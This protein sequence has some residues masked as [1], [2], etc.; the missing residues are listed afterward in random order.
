MIRHSKHL[1]RHKGF[2]MRKYLFF[3]LF[4][5]FIWTTSHS[6]FTKESESFLYAKIDSLKKAVSSLNGK[7]KVD[8]LNSIVDQYQI[9]DEDNQMQID[10]AGPYAR[11][12]HNYAVE[13]GYKRGLGYACLKLGYINLVWATVHKNDK[14]NSF[15]YAD[16]LK[17][18]EK[19]ITEAMQ[20]SKEINDLIMRG[21]AYA[22]LA[23]LEGL[24]GN[25]AQQL[26]YHKEA[27]SNIER[28]T[29]QPKG[30][31][32]EQVYINCSECI[33]QEFRLAELYGGLAR[34]NSNKIEAKVALRKAVELYKK[35][36]AYPA[37]SNTYS[38]LISLT[39][40]NANPEGGTEII[41][42]AI[43]YFKKVGD[44]RQ[45]G[46]FYRR[47]ATIVGVK[48]DSEVGIEYFKKALFYSQEAGDQQGE[49]SATTMISASSFATGD[50]ENSLE[51][52][53]KSIELVEKMVAAQGNKKIK[54]DEWG[55]AYYWMARIYS[56]AGGDYETALSFMRKSLLYYNHSPNP[57][58]LWTAAIGEIY[59]LKGD[60]DSS[61]YYLR[62][63]EKSPGNSVGTLYLGR[64]YISLGQYDKALPLINN[65]LNA[66]N[67]NA[68]YGNLGGGYTDLAKVWL[69]K[70][71]YPKALINARTGHILLKRTKRNDRFI[72]NCQVLSEIFTKVR[73]YDS[74]YFYLKQYTYLKD[75]FLTRQF[76]IRLN[77]YKKQAE[78]E[79]KTS[80]INLLNKDNQLKEQKLKQEA[81][82]KKGLIVG[83]IL[84]F[85][86][87]VF[88]F[89]TLLLKRK[90]ERLRLVKDFELQQM[91]NEKKQ[92]ELEMQALRAQMNP[93]F[94]FNC[95]SSINRFIL[96]NDSKIASNYLTRFSRLMRMVL[97][98]SQKSL[99][100][101]DDELEM[102]ELYLEMERLRF[103]NSF[104]YGITFLNTVDSDNVFI[105]PL[106]LQPFCENA[107]WH[108][109]MNKEGQGRLDI[110]LNL[111]NN[112]L[113][114]VIRDN[115]VG[116]EKA[117]ELKS[118]T[119]EK[120]KSMGLKIT[121][122]RLALLNREKGLHTFYEIEDLKDENG[123]GIGTKV[124]LKISFQTSV[125][126]F[127]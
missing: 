9:M 91:E 93:H 106:L 22:E 44:M 125:E 86:L 76:Y 114:C 98:N 89:R 109:L 123:N 5:V 7:D 96:K 80:Q 37:V 35:A 122:E 92:I 105:P 2:V 3:T 74:A 26:K 120:E 78:E 104:D 41:N 10:S 79:R 29:V 75:S 43:S 50:F 119:A 31:Y 97:N 66:A 16:T 94:I 85:L 63:F 100:S 34:L 82:L 55:K 54:N 32:R 42:D 111:D 87:G 113:S 60:Y 52:S 30:E 39:N 38:N 59:R 65:N 95:L 40:E 116:R 126:E 127:V 4:P 15:N 110:E 118:K 56:A 28:Q 77:D 99:I 14:S 13:I 88:V 23:W 36:E 17:S 62:R 18:I 108:G 61:M 90:N 46:D 57:P 19:L 101:L 71:D 69:G 51:F 83:L 58:E 117:E 67:I 102:L 103:R 49:L 53:K 45:V 11:Q 124:N 47:L 33:G 81:T 84:L 64:L 115:G 107:I 70:K 12:A 24:K 68:N 20:T 48:S 25:K 1:N 21:S 72:D 121:T 6:Q 8:C 73:K 27:I 112:I